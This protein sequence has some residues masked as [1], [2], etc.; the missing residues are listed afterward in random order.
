MLTAKAGGKEFEI[1]PAGLHP[2]RCIGVIDLGNQETPFFNED[3][4]AK[5]TRR[6]R[7][8]FEL[9]GDEKRADGKPFT[10][11]VDFTNSLHEKSALLPFLQ[12]WRGRPFT[13][14]EL[15][16]FDLTTIADKY[17]MIQTMHA[18]T[19]GN[20]KEYAKVTACLP[21]SVKDQPKPVNQVL[22]YD[23]D[24]HDDDIFGALPKY[25]QETIR[26]SYEWQLREN[27][28]NTTIRTQDIDV[29]GNI[30]VNS[31]GDDAEESINLDDIPF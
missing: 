29:E 19:K 10:I 18:F 7:L 28:Q 1:V 17:A 25:V 4:S 13:P 12:G 6:V 21:L 26:K 2:G 22:V 11:G 31:S 9:L 16:G 3:G 20:G 30:A 8:N 23:A 27:K 14:E 5:I 15:D 24:D